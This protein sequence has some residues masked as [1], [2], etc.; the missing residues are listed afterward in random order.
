[1]ARYNFGKRG[2]GAMAMRLFFPHFQAEANV[3]KVLEGKVEDM[4]SYYTQIRHL[5]SMAEVSNY[6]AQKL[7][8]LPDSS[9]DFIFA[10]PPFGRNIA[11]AELNIL[12]EAWLGTTT[13]VSKEAI[14]SSGRKWGVD[15][16]SEKMHGAFREMYRVLKP[17]RYALVEFNNSDPALRLFE[18]IKLAAVSAG[19]EICGMA[20]LDKQ[21]KSYNQAVGAIRGE[22]TVD[23]DVVFNLRRPPAVR[24]E[25]TIEDHDLE[26]QVIDVVREHLSSLPDRIKANPVKYSGE[27]RTG[28]TIHSVL[29][30]SLIPRGVSV[31]RLNLQLIERVCT[32]YFR[33]I[34]QHWYLRGESVAGGNGDALFEEAV[35]V[36]DELTAIAWL[37]QKVQYKPMLIGELK[38]QW[39]RAIG[40]L[41]SALSRELSLETLLS[42]NFWR[43]PDSNRWREPTDEEREKMNDDRSIRVLHDA[44]RFVS[45]TLHRTTTDL[46]RCDWID[47]LFKASRQVE[48]G[49]MQSLPVLRGFDA[50]EGYRLITRLFQSVLRENVPADVNARAQKQARAASNRITQSVRDDETARKGEALMGKSVW[51]FDKI[52]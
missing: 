38:P 40:L 51:L 35:D 3:L 25:Q 26:Q 1:M 34:G 43:D 14:T 2:N 10:D 8:F 33:K 41:P 12:W 46:E 21:H 7:S 20:I 27:H 45:G 31:E 6:P 48:D 49:D 9:V 4:L 44:E 23:K 47:I 39:M 28:A 29:M 17:G 15:S 11:Y 18:Q 13:D 36:K 32:R 16:Y 37:R 52:E 5:N 19:F 22:D 30:N 42:E 24:N 50:G